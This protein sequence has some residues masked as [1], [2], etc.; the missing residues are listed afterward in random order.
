MPARRGITDRRYGEAGGSDKPAI[1]KGLDIVTPY[2]EAGKRLVKYFTYGLPDNNRFHKPQRPDKPNN[3][4][5]LD[6]E[7]RGLRPNLF[8]WS[9]QYQK[10]VE[11]YGPLALSIEPVT[12]EYKGQEVREQEVKLAIPET[13][14]PP[15]ILSQLLGLQQEE[16]EGIT[17]EQLLPS[18]PKPADLDLIKRNS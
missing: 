12:G 15:E 17:L 1:Q 8:R 18:M 3:Q 4:E 6:E 13:E 2:A 10:W 7:F 5:R 11:T 9:P 14:L 16:I